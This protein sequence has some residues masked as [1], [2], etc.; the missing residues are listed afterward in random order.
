M[1]NKIYIFD[2]TLRDGEQA[3]G[4][5]LNIREKLEIAE[6]LSKLNVDIIEA[7]FPIS[8]KSDFDSVKEISKKIKDRKIAARANFK[9]IDTAG[10]ALKGAEQPVIHTF[11]SSSDIHLQHQL[12]KSREEV[13]ELAGQA[14]KRSLK[15]TDVVEFSAMDATRSDRDFLCRLFEVAIKSGAGIINVPDTVGYAVPGEF[16][17]LYF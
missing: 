5:H 16:D 9:D 1:K 2:T 15:Y 7:G 8:S 14:V 3:P 4:I 11:I 17:R 12:K 10:E 13:L 6:Q